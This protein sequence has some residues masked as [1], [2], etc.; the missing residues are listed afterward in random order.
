MEWTWLRLAELLNRLVGR[1]CPMPPGIRLPRNKGPDRPDYRVL[2]IRERDLTSRV[3]I[4]PL[5]VT[6]KTEQF[7]HSFNIFRVSY[8]LTDIDFAQ[9]NGT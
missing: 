3:Q 5:Q 2:Q 8:E 4:R 1:A 7:S 6:V 9:T